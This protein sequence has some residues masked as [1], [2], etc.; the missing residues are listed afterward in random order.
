[1]SYYVDALAGHLSSTSFNDFDDVVPDSCLAF[2]TMAERVK[3]W[4]E[5]T[6]FFEQVGT[7]SDVND[8]SPLHFVKIA[9]E[10]QLMNFDFSNLDFS[11]L[12]GPDL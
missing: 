12:D 2:K 9:K 10:E 11:F 4:Y 6:E 3:Q 5:R 7:P 8:M 1:M